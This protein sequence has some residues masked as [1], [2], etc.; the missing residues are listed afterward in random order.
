[1]RRAMTILLTAV[2]GPSLVMP[3]AVARDSG[4]IDFGHHTDYY[5][6]AVRRQPM[7]NLGKFW[8]GVGNHAYDPH[9]SGES[10][11]YPPWSFC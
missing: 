1:M 4:K 6:S 2:L 10:S 9:C 3:M 11:K 5:G 7:H 8:R